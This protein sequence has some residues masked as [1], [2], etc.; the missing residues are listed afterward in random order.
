MKSKSVVKNQ[1]LKPVPVDRSELRPVD[2][3]F[4]SSVMFDLGILPLEGTNQDMS[5]PLGQISVEE[6]RVIKRKFR[7]MWRKLMRKQTAHR[8]RS[9]RSSGR[10]ISVEDA[11]ALAKKSV[12]AKFG[13]GKQI[14]SKQDKQNRKRAVFES[15]WT[16]V[17]A[18]MLLKFESLERDSTDTTEKTGQGPDVE[19]GDS[20]RVPI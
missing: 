16:S 6:A 17:I 18:P 10:N 15:V 2:R 3:A 7:K 9:Y 11:E 4:I 12:G 8:A 20:A 14:P 5:R 19:L 13:Q 1:R